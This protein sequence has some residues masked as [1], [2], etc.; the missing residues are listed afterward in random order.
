MQTDARKQA[1]V[2]IRRGR[3]RGK[4][5]GEMKGAK[6]SDLNNDGACARPHGRAQCDGRERSYDRSG[7]GRPSDS[8]GR[9]GGDSTR[10]GGWPIDAAI[11]PFKFQRED[12]WPISAAV[13]SAEKALYLSDGALVAKPDAISNTL[14]QLGT[15]NA[16]MH[17]DIIQGGKRPRN[18]T[19][20]R[21]NL[22]KVVLR[23][24]PIAVTQLPKMDENALKNLATAV[25][26][27]SS[28]FAGPP[29]LLAGIE[30]RM[31]E[32]L[33]VETASSPSPSSPSLASSSVSSASSAPSPLTKASRSTPLPPT[34]ALVMV[35]DA[36]E[37][38]KPSYGMSQHLWDAAL[39]HTSAD[40]AT[41]DA[42][43]RGSE[44]ATLLKLLARNGKL[45]PPT[46]IHNLMECCATKL[47]TMDARN[48]TDLVWG[49]SKLMIVLPDT[50]SEHLS[51]VLVRL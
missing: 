8:R 23:L 11:R 30:Q 20:L 48:L 7:R 14:L 51:A 19:N 42:T 13:Q 33:L 2:Q 10:E 38:H 6:N 28:T 24:Y 15:A 17:K 45:P 4:G 43:L 1:L 36:F 27:L 9:G 40:V 26:L 22:Q 41:L 46:A 3:G 34:A 37:R 35:L 50:H 25:G 44:L 39:A 31:T 21:E 5:R 49:C 18:M 16:E 12:G 32:L 29:L 47:H